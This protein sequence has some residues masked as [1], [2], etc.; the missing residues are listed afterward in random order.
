MQPSLE[1]KIPERLEVLLVQ[2]GE[3][4]KMIEIENTLEAMQSILGEYIEEFMPYDDGVAILCSEEE[5]EKG[6]LPNREIYTEPK[7]IEMSYEQ[8]KERFRQI[9][10][11]GEQHLTGYLVFSQESFQEPYSEQSRN[12]KISSTNKAFTSKTGAKS[13]FGSCLDG[14]DPCL[15][16]DRYM[17]DEE[18]GEDGWKI[19]R[20]YVKEDKGQYLDTIMGDFLIC[21][22]S[23]ETGSYQSFPKPLME[24]YFEKLRYPEQFE[25]K[26]EQWK[27][28]PFHPRAKEREQ[29]RETTGNP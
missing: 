23:E 2:P 29:Q 24:K 10:Q 21:T 20:C 17:A 16:L 12:Y 25:E 1:P 8:M 26:D 7:K 4:P 11:V 6:L 5:R 14:T 3:P 18:G 19:E 28:V 22:F 13:I 15:R 27:A 9:E